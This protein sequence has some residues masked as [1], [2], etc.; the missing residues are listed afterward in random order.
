[1]T[2]E[3]AQLASK[4]PTA[5]ARIISTAENFRIARPALEA[6]HKINENCK[7]PVLGITGT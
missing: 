5:I 3:V 6:I 4:N 1:L 2:D 7:T